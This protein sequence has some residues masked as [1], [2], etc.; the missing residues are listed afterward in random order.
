VRS[1]PSMS[2]VVVMMGDVAV[3]SSSSFRNQFASSGAATSRMNLWTGKTL[4]PTQKGPVRAVLRQTE[5]S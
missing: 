2:V 3:T 5:L 1:F 4:P